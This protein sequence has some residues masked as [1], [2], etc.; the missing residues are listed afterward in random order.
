MSDVVLPLLLLLLDP[1]VVESTDSVVEPV[2]VAVVVITVVD[3]VVGSTVVP[4]A[5]VPVDSTVV[6]TAVVSLPLLVVGPVA[7][8]GLPPLLV[9]SA[10][11]LPLE[12]VCGASV[13]VSAGE[14]GPHPEATASRQHR[15]ETSRTS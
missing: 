2:P 10:G 6:A 9:D 14:L 8:V 4:T 7:V 11:T 12:L 15:H 3:A 13:V 1:V 5:V